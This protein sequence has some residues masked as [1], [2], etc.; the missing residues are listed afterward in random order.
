MYFNGRVLSV[1]IIG[2]WEFKIKKNFRGLLFLGAAYNFETQSDYDIPSDVNPD[3]SHFP[4]QYIS[5]NMGWGLTYALSKKASVYFS[6][7]FNFGGYKG[8]ED[9]F[10]SNSK[11]IASNNLS[12][13]GIKYHFKH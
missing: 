4:K 1:P 11:R 3:L 2:K 8:R 13:I 6:E 7:G 5:G 10:L 9:R 12:V